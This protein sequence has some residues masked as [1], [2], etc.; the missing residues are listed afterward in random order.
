MLYL[1]SVNHQKDTPEALFI[2]LTWV[3]SLA[4]PL[5]GFKPGDA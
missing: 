4:S 1:V 2:A 5:E 3:P